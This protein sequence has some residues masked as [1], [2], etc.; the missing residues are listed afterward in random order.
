MAADGQ[1]RIDGSDAV[2]GSDTDTAQ[3]RQSDAGDQSL[4]DTEF[5][6]AGAEDKGQHD[7]DEVTHG[8]GKLSGNLG[9]GREALDD[10]DLV[11]L[12][13]GIQEHKD[14]AEDVEC[15]GILCKLFVFQHMI[16]S[17]FL[18]CFG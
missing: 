4:A 13:A 11:I 8:H 9:P 17:P 3:S 10:V 16:L 18:N 12:Q 2:G 5:D 6:E 14:D 15:D 1:F 7:T